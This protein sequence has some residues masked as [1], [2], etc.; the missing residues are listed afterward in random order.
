MPTILIVPLALVWLVNHPDYQL[1][2]QGHVVLY[3]TRDHAPAGSSKENG[4][5]G[6]DV[7]PIKNPMIPLARFLLHRFLIGQTKSSQK[8]R[9][10]IGHEQSLMA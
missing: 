10:M 8:I 5:N 4:N 7:E 9:S 2:K 6:S 1:P 3:G